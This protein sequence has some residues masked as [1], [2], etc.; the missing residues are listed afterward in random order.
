MKRLLIILLIVAVVVISGCFLWSV[1]APILTF[2]HPAPPVILTPSAEAAPQ[3]TPEPILV[4]ELTKAPLTG[5]SET[6]IT[7]EGDR[8]T[9]VIK[10]VEPDGIV[11]RTSDGVSKL[12]FKNLP[13]EVGVKYGYDP[14]LETQFLRYRNSGEIK[15]YQT[16]IAIRT[17]EAQ[18]TE[19]FFEKIESKNEAIASS[20]RKKL[21]IAKWNRDIDQ[22]LLNDLEA[23]IQVASA[24]PDQLVTLEKEKFKRNTDLQEAQK[25][26]NEAEAEL[27][28]PP[29]IAVSTP[30]PTPTPTPGFIASISA[31]LSGFFP[32]IMHN[33]Q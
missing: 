1:K 31:R 30:V 28:P 18:K 12:K 25:R 6:F 27:D 8:F 3:P 2:I 19:T 29:S 5:T 17:H 23:T 26:V 10:R 13:H 7:L 22:K 16:A 24:H 14:E 4:L 32:H 33:S 9:G 20:P 11:L 21:E 15:S